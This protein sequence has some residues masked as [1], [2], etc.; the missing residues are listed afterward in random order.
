MKKAKGAR[1]DEML[2]EA[3]A[4]PFSSGFFKPKAPVNHS[5]NRGKPGK[6]LFFHNQLQRNIH[7]GLQGFA[8]QILDGVFKSG[9]DLQV[10]LL[11]HG[12]GHSPFSTATRASSV[13]SMP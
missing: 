10:R 9:F 11:L 7:Q 12:S 4:L 8:A 2:G 13:A 5:V 1:L 3:S 6:R